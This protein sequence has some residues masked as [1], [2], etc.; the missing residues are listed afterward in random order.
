MSI[1]HYDEVYDICCDA[2]I[3][4]DERTEQ[5]AGMIP[6]FEKHMKLS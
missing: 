3:D 1:G 5:N 6:T 4:L 2:C